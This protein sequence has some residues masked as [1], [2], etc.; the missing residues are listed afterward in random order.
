MLDNTAAQAATT[1]EDVV[2]ADLAA[3]IDRL[4]ELEEYGIDE[5]YRALAVKAQE[6]RGPLTS[7]LRAMRQYGTGELARRA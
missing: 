2:I 3:I 1:A 4:D 5:G 6:A 7:A